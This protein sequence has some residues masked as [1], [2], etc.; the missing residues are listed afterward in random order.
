MR[1][2]LCTNCNKYLGEIKDAKLLK[3]I[4]FLC[5]KCKNTINGKPE[6][7]LMKDFFGI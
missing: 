1:K 6:I 7:D 5:P 2:I 3:G 4:A